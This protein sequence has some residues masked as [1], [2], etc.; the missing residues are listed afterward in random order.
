MSPLEEKVDAI[1]DSAVS[2]AM[3]SGY[4]DRVNMHE[5]KNAPGTGMTCAVWVQRIRPILA[6]GLNNTSGQIALNVRLYLPMLV[7]PQDYIDPQM[8]KATSALMAAYSSDFTMDGLIKNIDLFGAHGIALE[9]LAGY[10]TIGQTK[11]RAMTISVP[12]NVNDLFAQ[13]P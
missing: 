9:A 7:E 11:Y 4:F 2:H 5:P 13:N 3:S 6:S 8:V 1:F 12:C 10:T